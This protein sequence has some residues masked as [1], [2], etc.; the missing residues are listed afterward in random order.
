MVAAAGLHPVLPG[1]P[2]AFWQQRPAGG[3]G[4]ATR[5][6]AVGRAARL[7]MPAL[8][9]LLLLLGVPPELLR[10]LPWLLPPPRHA[11]P[12]HASC[13]LPQLLPGP[14]SPLPP[15]SAAISAASLRWQSMPATLPA[16]SAAATSSAQ[17]PSRCTGCGARQQEMVASSSRQAGTRSCT[18]RL[19]AGCSQG[20]AAAWEEADGAKGRWGGARKVA[21]TLV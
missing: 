8:L 1:C 5:Q 13:Q 6:T 15:A 4:A 20:S 19:P 11:A 7:P 2:H 18:L 14:C 21:G 17:L 12:A 10:L 9:L 3:A 16:A